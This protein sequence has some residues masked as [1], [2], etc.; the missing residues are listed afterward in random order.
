[1]LLDAYYKM[2]YYE[3]LLQGRASSSFYLT[4]PKTVDCSG[5]A[6]T[7]IYCGYSSSNYGYYYPGVRTVYAQPYE[8]MLSQTAKLAL[9]VRPRSNIIVGTGTTPPAADDYCME[10]EIVD[11]LTC[12]SSEWRMHDDGRL[13]Y[14]KTMTNNS[15]ATLTITEV[16][17]AEFWCTSG[18]TYIATHPQVLVM[19][20]VLEE[21]IVVE[22]GETFTV[23]VTHKFQIA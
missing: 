22:P 7:T 2:R 3:A 10:S 14:Y 15:G 21:P 19:R 20:E 16:G 9:S 6:H 12:Q 23:S 13:I 4:V 5:V 11:G 18:S 8:G 1:M 17:L